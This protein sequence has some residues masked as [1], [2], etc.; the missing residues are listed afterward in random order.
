VRFDAEEGGALP[1]VTGE[2]FVLMR[3]AEY[4][5]GRSA[6]A[7][8][9]FCPAAV[10]GRAGWLGVSR[11]HC[12][13]VVRAAGTSAS[14]FLVLGKGKYLHVNGTNVMGKGSGA[15]EQPGDERALRDGDEISL[16]KTVHVKVSCA[17]LVLFANVEHLSVAER[18]ELEAA[19]RELEELTIG[20]VELASKLDERAAVAVFP[21][22]PTKIS[23]LLLKA[24]CQCVPIVTVPRFIEQRGIPSEQ[25]S[26]RPGPIGTALDPVKGAESRERTLGTTG[27]ALERRAV[28]GR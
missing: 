7:L 2:Q 1:A 22:Q 24:V 27:P 6:L 18:S 25:G 23:N 28:K 17:T 19:R 5:L 26:R 12:R 13:L 16:S 3:G 10:K 15:L 8:E 21:A 20:R 14:L 11:E 9:G 4:A